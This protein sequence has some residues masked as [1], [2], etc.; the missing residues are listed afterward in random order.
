[1]T[2]IT[3]NGEEYLYDLDEGGAIVTYEELCDIAGISPKDSPTVTCR[4]PGRVA[5]ELRAGD[6]GPP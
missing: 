5:H 1:M 2:A 4:A 3:M 6:I